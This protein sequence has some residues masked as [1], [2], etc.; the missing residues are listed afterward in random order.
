MDKTT[1]YD[2]L[3]NKSAREIFSSTT[4]NQ[5]VLGGCPLKR[6]SFMGFF[7]FFV[8]ELLLFLVFSLIEFKTKY[9][10]NLAAFSMF[11]IMFVFAAVRGSG[12]ADY[13]N[14][15]WF[16]KDIGTDF[17]KVLNFSYPVEFSFRFASYL[18]NLLGISR[19]W[20]IALMNFLSIAP[21]TYVVIKKSANPFLSALIFL[22]VFLQFDMQ[23]SRT[24]TAIG[25]GLL[26][27]YEASE[28]NRIRSLLALVLA[29]S[30]HKSAV[31]LLPFLLYLEIDLSNITK[32]IIV[33]ISLV[34]SVFSKV[35]FGL[36]A[37]IFSR[38]GLSRLAR[39]IVTYTFE[40]KFAYGMKLYDPR[41]I[42]FFLLFIVSIMYLSEKHFEDDR[43][44]K[45]SVKGMVFGLCVMLVFRSSTAIAFRF[46]SYF[47]VLEM[48]YIPMMVNKLKYKDSLA[49][50]LLV[51]SVVVFLLPYALNIAISA[52]DYDFFFTNPMAI[53]SLR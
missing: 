38:V 1:F 41:I 39:K 43:M 33:F 52:P 42:F 22:P 25:L 8:L 50:F 40:G 19:Q 46:S 26:A 29:I 24:A 48:F 20:V 35:F 3:M 49:A 27:I 4:S 30:F 10:K 36:A 6:K 34:V 21:V 14:Y 9:Q 28:K 44:A 37:N 18:V 32:C 11:F 16:A 45:A 15:L 17:S 31:I 5:G 13:Y 23:T 2:I 53:E 12:D 7:L 51:L 47:A